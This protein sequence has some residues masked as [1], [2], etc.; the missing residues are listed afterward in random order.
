MDIIDKFCKLFCE[1]NVQN[2]INLFSENAVYIDCLYGKFKGKDEISKFYIRCHNEA[3]N[4]QFTPF[5]KVINGNFCA[6]EWN[7]SFI[8]NMPLSK[9]KTIKTEGGSFLKI[10]NQKIVYYRDYSD[11]ILFLLQGNVSDKKIINFYKK[12]YSL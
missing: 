10:L 11:S 1:N 7:F 12:K 5:N 8:S 4:Y 6:F 2:F 9:A 3:Y